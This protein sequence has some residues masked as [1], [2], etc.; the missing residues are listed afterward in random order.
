MYYISNTKKPIRMMGGCRATS[1][2]V[3]DSVEI[4][5][6]KVFEDTVVTLV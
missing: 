5:L 1:H 3:V 2:I 4:N 6:R